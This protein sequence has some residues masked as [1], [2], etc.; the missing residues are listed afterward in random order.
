MTWYQ[1]GERM[2][3]KDL[4]ELEKKLHEYIKNNDFETKKWSTPDA[5]MR[6]GVDEKEIYK[7]LA[8][9]SKHVKNN[10]YIHYSDG[11]LRISAE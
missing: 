5:A 9:L 1:Y 2:G 6:L 3:F 7:A 10:I 4:S 11:G 8:N